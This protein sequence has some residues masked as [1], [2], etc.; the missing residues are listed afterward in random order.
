MP[1]SST[2]VDMLFYQGAY[3][4]C[5][6]FMLLSLIAV[7]YLYKNFDSQ[8]KKKWMIG[9]TFYAIVLF[10]ADLTSLRNFLLFLIPLMFTYATAIFLKEGGNPYEWIK[11]K[12]LLAL[13]GFTIICT[14]VCYLH[15]R[16]LCAKVGFD[17]VM[18]SNGFIEPSI[19]FKQ[20]GETIGD[21][22]K[23]FGVHK[24]DSMI[25]ISSIYSCIMLL[26][27]VFTSL[28][29]P[30]AIIR[31]LKKIKNHSIKYLY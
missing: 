20:S 5:I 31:T 4:Y 7:R 25:S 14:G 10:F 29:L 1:I 12:K 21:I 26:Y 16:Y 30:I 2:Y 6:L 11:E 19:L 3:D 24:T 13:L 23:L 17:G 18:T 8:D 22:L 15:Y 28:I 27:F 9:L